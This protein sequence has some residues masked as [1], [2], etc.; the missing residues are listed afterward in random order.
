MSDFKA[1]APDLHSDPK[2]R[3]EAQCQGNTEQAEQ[4]GQQLSLESSPWFGPEVEPEDQKRAFLVASLL[5]ALRRQEEG[6]AVVTP[7]HRVGK[8]KLRGGSRGSVAEGILSWAL[9]CYARPREQTLKE[10]EVRPAVRISPVLALHRATASP[11][12]SPGLW[13]SRGHC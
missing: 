3:L 5:Q 6:R 11:L 12:P 7:F 10:T 1:C 9:I 13:A 8:A 4:L 2:L